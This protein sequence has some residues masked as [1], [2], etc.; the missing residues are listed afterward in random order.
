[1]ETVSYQRCCLAGDGPKVVSVSSHSVP[2]KIYEC[3]IPDNDS[4]P[5]T[6]IC[7]CEG[8]DYRGHCTH[9]PEAIA[10]L[11]PWSQATA[12]TQQTDQQRADMICPRCGNDT[13]WVTEVV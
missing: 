2:G 11:C 7:E 5:G 3:L 1:M 12:P 6:V 8:F 13:E 10:Q 4:D 9:Q